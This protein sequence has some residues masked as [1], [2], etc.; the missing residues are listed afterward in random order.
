ML[1]AIQLLQLNP[2]ILIYVLPRDSLT[3]KLPMHFLMCL[4]KLLL[5]SLTLPGKSCL[6]VNTLALYQLHPYCTKKKIVPQQEMVLIFLEFSQ[7]KVGMN[8]SKNNQSPN[9]LIFCFRFC[10]QLRSMGVRGKRWHQSI[11]RQT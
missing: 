1:I 3:Y 5:P 4:S 7:V 9:E 10:I 2:F 11:H 6:V 8:I